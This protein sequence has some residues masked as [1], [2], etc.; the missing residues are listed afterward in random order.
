MIVRRLAHHLRS[1]RSLFRAT[2]RP[3]GV[4]AAL[5]SGR[6]PVEVRLPAHGLAVRVRSALELLVLKEVVLDAEYDGWIAERGDGFAVVDV[7]AGFG[8]FAVRAARRFAGG[9][10]VACEPSPDSVAL[11]E[12]NLA[13]NGV[14]NATVLPVA[15]TGEPCES[16]VLDGDDVPP[17]L[18]RARPAAS[19]A[20]PPGSRV[21]E[22]MSLAAVFDRCGLARCDLLKLDCEGA[23]A[24]ILL[25]A[26]AEVLGR[27]NRIAAELHCGVDGPDGLAIR[28]RLSSL[29]FA[30]RIAP[31]PLRADRCHLLARKET[32]GPDRGPE[33]RD[34]LAAPPGTP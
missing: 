32:S 13:A 2:E 10:V 11:L 5:L 18:R 3:L 6:V 31:N 22:A 28:A 27:V 23:E 30:V 25:G 26:P 12:A 20:P 9:T 15:V 17:V 14:Q 29:G 8:A 1:A 34:G 24:E 33:A 21:V 16:A 7:G 4:A 19:G